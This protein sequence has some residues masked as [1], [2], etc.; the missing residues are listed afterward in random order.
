MQICRKRFEGITYILYEGIHHMYVLYIYIHLPSVLWRVKARLSYDFTFTRPNTRPVH[1]WSNI[2][3]V[4][5][6]R[7]ACRCLHAAAARSERRW[8]RC[9]TVGWRMPRD[10]RPVTK[11]VY[12]ILRTLQ[13]TRGH[14]H[15]YVIERL[16]HWS[17]KIY[18][19]KQ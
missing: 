16:E 2:F 6:P 12:C 4:C 19:D 5:L 10:P 15:T 9:T 18:T 8:P 1:Q 17:I 11:Q 14:I 7:R 3:K 13:S